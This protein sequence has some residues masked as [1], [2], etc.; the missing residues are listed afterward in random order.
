MSFISR[1]LLFKID[2]VDLFVSFL[3]ISWWEI[4]ETSCMHFGRRIFCIVL[5]TCL[6]VEPHI[7]VLSERAPNLALAIRVYPIDS[8]V[9]I[10]AL[11]EHLRLGIDP[12]SKL[13]LKV[14]D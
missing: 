13:A 6:L 2:V 7:V 4:I 9:S 10:P 8:K 14:S 3:K 12:L 1:L 11:S 5:T